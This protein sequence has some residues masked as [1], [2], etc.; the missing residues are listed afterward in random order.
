[1][2]ARDEWR[3]LLMDMVHTYDLTAAGKIKLSVHQ[4]RVQYTFV[5]RKILNYRQN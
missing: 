4:D 1:V 2:L 5:T 3:R